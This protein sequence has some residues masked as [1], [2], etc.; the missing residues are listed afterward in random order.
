MNQ[1]ARPAQPPHP[2]TSS[3]SSSSGTS[4]TNNVVNDSNSVQSMPEMPHPT[5][6]EEVRNL[7]EEPSINSSGPVEIT[8]IRPSGQNTVPRNFFS[9]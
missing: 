8:T 1:P 9:C 5:A 4:P 3:S 2:P 7:I 6:D